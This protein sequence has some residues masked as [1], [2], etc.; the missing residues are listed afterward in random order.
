MARFLPAAL[1]VA[2][3]VPACAASDDAGTVVGGDAAVDAGRTVDARQVV[4]RGTTTDTSGAMDGS[5]TRVDA[6]SDAGTSDVARAADA[7]TPADGAASA[8]GCGPR[9]LCN[10][11]IDNNCDGRVDETCPCIPGTVQGCF[12]GPP[13][14][15]GAG[16]CVDGHQTCLGTGEFGMWSDCTGGLGPSPEVCDGADNDCNGVVDDGLSCTPAGTCPAAGDPRVPP[17]RPFIAYHLDGSTF[18]PG[19]AT[20][21]RWRV[22]GGPCDQLLYA[23]RTRVSYTLGGASSDPRESTGAALDFRPTLSGDYTV[24]LTVTPASGPVFTCTFVIAVRAPGVR[25]ELCWDHTGAAPAGGDIDLWVHDPRGTADWGLTSGF[26]PDQTCGPY[27]CFNR[28]P[29]PLA[30]E[31]RQDWGYADSTG[32][33]C[34][35]PDS[36]GVC[37]NPRIDVDNNGRTSGTNSDSDPE[38]INVDDPRDGDRFRVAAYYWRGTVA[39]QP[40]LN[41]YCGGALRATLG[42]AMVGGALY[43]S[44]PVPGFASGLGAFDRT[45]SFWRI[46]DVRVH[47]PADTCDV[48]PLVPSGATSGACVDTSTDRSFDGPCHLRAP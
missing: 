18:F 31:S 42:G 7:G 19:A 29:Q 11:G 4:D 25:F 20:A 23:T 24:T 13:G 12:A 34:R 45:A 38:N 30:S 14:R 28:N 5:G 36:G 43:G 17:G 21:W 33:A 1:L 15:R 3:L 22:V 44:A 39:Q 10:D 8:D 16:S 47:E 32:S 9:E 40:M 48:V 27:N 2:G 35:A 6:G 41:I 26:D 46:A 37:H